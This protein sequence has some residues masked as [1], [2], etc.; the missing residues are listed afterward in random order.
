[1]G[2]LLAY[3]LT[4]AW[5]SLKRESPWLNSIKKFNIN[6]AL[7]MIIITCATNNYLFK[8]LTKH[9]FKKQIIAQHQQQPINQLQTQYQALHQRL[10]DIGFSWKNQSK[11]AVIVGYRNNQPLYLCQKK[12]GMYFFGGT[13]RKNTCQII[14]NSKVINTKNFTILNGPQQAILWKPWPNYYQTPEK[15]AFSVV[16][17]FNGKNALFVCRVIFNNRIYIGTNTIPNNC[18]FIVKEKLISAPSLQYL[19]AI[20]K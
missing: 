4:Y 17:G 18:L 14:K 3:T 20:E 13:V 15:S 16:T 7:F 8:T 1:I 12:M 9:F 10:L 19:Y 11:H 6:L 2:L 5:T